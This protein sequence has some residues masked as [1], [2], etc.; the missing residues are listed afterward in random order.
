MNLVDWETKPLLLGVHIHL[1]SVP[2]KG[3]RPSCYLNN[4]TLRLV[5]EGPAASHCDRCVH[6]HSHNGPRST[7]S[8]C[9][10]FLEGPW[11]SHFALGLS[12]SP[13]KW[14]NIKCQGQQCWG[15]ASF[16]HPGAAPGHGVSLRGA[17]SVWAQAHRGSLSGGYP[18]LQR[19]LAAYRGTG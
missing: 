19:G 17:S 11:A 1:C 5:Q 3:A 2:A 4:S 18:M 16:D 10:G 6:I 13:V 15:E 12:F 8:C 14:S 7:L 9:L